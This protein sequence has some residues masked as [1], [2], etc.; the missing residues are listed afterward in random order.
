MDDSLSDPHQSTDGANDRYDTDAAY[1]GRAREVKLG[2]SA[3]AGV[4]YHRDIHGSFRFRI[5]AQYRI[6]GLS[7]LAR[8]TGEA[9]WRTA[10]DLQLGY[11]AGAATY[12][13]GRGFAMLVFLEEL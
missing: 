10:A 7:R 4:F 12:P 8:L 5:G 3:I 2:A 1:L 9:R 6:P 11:L 13:A